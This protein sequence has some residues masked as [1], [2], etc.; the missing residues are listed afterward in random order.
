MEDLPEKIIKEIQDRNYAILNL[1]DAIADFEKDILTQAINQFGV[2]KAAEKL[3]IDYST[4]K[5]KKKR[6]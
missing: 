6:F 5:R 3:G 2:R 1:K 4:L